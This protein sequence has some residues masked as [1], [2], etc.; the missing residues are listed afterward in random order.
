MKSNKLTKKIHLRK[1]NPQKMHAYL[2]HPCLVYIEDR[3][4][5]KEK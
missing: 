5:T 2:S 3:G 1:S 4:F